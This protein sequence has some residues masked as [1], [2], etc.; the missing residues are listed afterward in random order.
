MS[1]GY[2]W[3]T[4]EQK[5]SRG[6]ARATMQK[7]LA[8]LD[9]SEQRPSQKDSDKT[10]KQSPVSRSCQ[11]SIPRDKQEHRAINHIQYIVIIRVTIIGKKTF[12]SFQ[13]CVV[14]L[15]IQL[16]LSRPLSGFVSIVL[17]WPNWKRSQS[18]LIKI[19]DY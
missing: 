10:S 1:V 4:P 2:M 13:N 5:P 14:G 3:V 9:I 6:M 16:P 17:T 19:F 18:S 7:C 12:M 8:S 11:W 15:A